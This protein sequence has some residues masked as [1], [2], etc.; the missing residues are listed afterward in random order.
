MIIKLLLKKLMGNYQARKVKINAVKEKIKN[1]N[2]V[3]YYETNC[4]VG[5]AYHEL[6]FPD[7][8]G[9][10]YR[11][12]LKKRAD[13]IESHVS[14]QNRKGIDIGCAVGG[15][16]FELAQRGALMLGIDFNPD[17]IEIAQ[18]L[19]DIYRTGCLFNCQESLE[20]IKSP[21]LLA[22]FDF[23]VWF[24]QWMWLVKQH[25]IEEGKNALYLVSKRIKH[26]F[27]ETSIGD[28]GAGDVMLEHGITTPEAVIQL[29]KEN[30]LYS[31]FVECKRGDGTSLNR[32]IFYCSGNRSCDYFGFS[33][34][35][36]RTGA[37]TCIKNFSSKLDLYNNE[38]NALKKIV[39]RHFPKI[40]SANNG[41]VVMDYCGEPLTLENMPV[42]Y[43]KQCEEIIKDL[44]SCD[45]IHRDINP[46][47]LLL[48]SGVIM[49]IDFGYSGCLSSPVD[50]DLPNSKNN[51]PYELGYFTFRHPERF[52]DRYSLQQS[53]AFIKIKSNWLQ[54][55]DPSEHR[56]DTKS[57]K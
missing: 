57:K 18:D 42:D 35:V 53:I 30:T 49:L 45:I 40:K 47:N 1:L 28:A 24:S 25:G 15:I 36:V 6:P 2:K 29:L 21:N 12:D 41:I 8:K 10:V 14:L 50:N 43:E 27:F 38:V 9:A 31:S 22:N 4:P 11:K 51:L 26:L 32:S 54:T 44:K 56:I 37:N 3:K 13:I 34:S 39:G 48:R 17:E 7:F 19:E 33:S 5:V 52:D 55:W 16:S 46:T 23:A 20:A